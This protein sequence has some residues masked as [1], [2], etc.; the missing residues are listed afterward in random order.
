MKRKILTIFL[1][2]TSLFGYL[3]WGGNSHV[4]LAQAEAEIFSKLITDPISV[5]HPFILLP[6]FGQLMLFLT[7][8]QRKPSKFLTYIGIGSLGSLLSFMCVIG[9]MSLNYKIFFS[10]IP[11]LIVA[12]L[13]I[14]LTSRMNKK[15][16]QES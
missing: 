16:E 7:L 5:I 14:K 6:L 1:I 8:F 9:L 2:I 13:T 11:F 4:F 10:T 15:I 12:I 3:E